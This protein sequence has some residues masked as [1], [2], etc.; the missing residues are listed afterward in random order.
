MATTKLIIRNY[1]S[2]INRNG[3]TLIFVLYTHKGKSTLLSTGESIHP[4]YWDKVNCRIRKSYSGQMKL[5][6]FLQSF[7]ERVDEVV[8]DARV[9]NVEP[10]TSYVVNTFRKIE[11]GNGLSNKLSFFE[12]FDQWLETKKVDCSPGTIR[13]FGT[14]KTHLINYQASK[15]IKID[16][17][18]FNLNFYDA[19]KNYF[20]GKLGNCSNSFGSHIKR[21]KIIL[22]SA[23]ERGYNKNLEFKNK[24][25]KVVSSAADTIYL[26]EEELKKIYDLDL[27]GNR[28]LDTV[29]DLFIVACYTGL[30]YSDFRQ[31]KPENIKDGFIHIKTQKTSQNVMIPWHKYVEEILAKWEGILPPAISNQKFNEYV[32]EVCEMAKINERISVSSDRGGKRKDVVFKKFELV[33]A[34]SAR[35]SFATNLY[36]QG[37]PSIFIMKITGHKSE[38]EFLRYVKI[39]EEQAMKKLKEFWGK[40]HYRNVKVM[41][42]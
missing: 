33:S 26:N 24:G 15:R 40:K 35:R 19:F 9:Q 29:R 30:R 31:I 37:F 28:R 27:S 5:N 11:N 14:T 38:K 10:T 7:K 22:N 34:H 3:K 39:D 21:I 42:S 18:S 32:K 4:H 41:A 1:S 2:T 23:T 8:R 6:L 20:V 12:F 13:G 36:L 25:F 16:W 17:D